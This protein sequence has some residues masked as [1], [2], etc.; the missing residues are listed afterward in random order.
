MEETSAF[1]LVSNTHPACRDALLEYL[2]DP[3]MIE[4]SSSDSFSVQA[5]HDNYELAYF[6]HIMNNWE[7]DRN[8]MVKKR[9][10]KPVMESM[11]ILTSI[12]GVL[13]PC[14]IQESIGSSIQSL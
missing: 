3:E 6:E 2:Q 11:A 8:K 5:A 1:V 14:S 4:I 12:A 7:T 9:I 10:S 13:D